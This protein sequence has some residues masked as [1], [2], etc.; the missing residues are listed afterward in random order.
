MTPRMPSTTR[1]ARPIKKR[2]DDCNALLPEEKLTSIEYGGDEDDTDL[3]LCERC[4]DSYA[5]CYGCGLW[6]WAGKLSA[7]SDDMLARLYDA[8]T[9][10]AFAGN[11][12]FPELVCSDCQDEFKRAQKRRAQRRA[13]RARRAAAARAG[14]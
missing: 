14:G 13:S 12:G 11:G 4:L 8:D 2:C 10:E 9:I 5:Q 6:F 1:P 7:L 3:S